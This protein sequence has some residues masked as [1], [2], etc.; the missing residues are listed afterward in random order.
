[1]CGVIGV[2][3]ISQMFFLVKIFAIFLK[4]LILRNHGLLCAGETIEEAFYLT[5]YA[6]LACQNQVIGCLFI[7]ISD[8]YGDSCS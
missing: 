5:Y 7:N 2:V 1:M 8:I 3:E 6:I 4:V